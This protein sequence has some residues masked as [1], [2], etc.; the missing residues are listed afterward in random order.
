MS[1]INPGGF[2]GVEGIVGRDAEVARYW[3]VLARQSLVLSAERRIGKTYILKKMEAGSHEA[4][5]TFY[6]DLERVH[7]ITELIGQLYRTVEKHLPK[8]KRAR[9]KFI[10]GWNALSAQRI[11][12]L[13]LPTT[14]A[15]W[16]ALLELAVND[17][18][19]LADDDQ[20]VVFMW[21]EF[22][23][24][25]YNLIEREGAD[26][27]I[28]LL[29][30]LRSLRQTRS[31]Q[32]R[33]LFTGSIGLH[34]I[35]KR[36]RREGNANSPVNDTMQET[37]PPMNSADIRELGARLAKALRT[38]PVDEEAI[39]SRAIGHVGGFAFHL[40]HVFDRL[41]QLG[42]P[43]TPEDV[44][45]VANALSS[46][47]SDPADLGNGIERLHRYYASED[48]PVCLGILDVLATSEAP[49]DLT[50]I[51]NLVRHAKPEVTDEQVRH[52]SLL[53]KQDH[54]L[55]S[56]EGRH[57]FRWGL[58]KRWWKANRV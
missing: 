48:V 1:V 7:S 19:D 58:V 3:E 47:D 14:S 51:A 56:D 34:L 33:F 2:L 49:L 12:E 16:K 13:S 5:L 20:M 11:E 8:L 26:R 23:L 40:H 52:A 10:R 24:M 31:R 55:T 38:P 43:A 44:D 29:D 50:T 37:V 53:L 45:H 41:N 9:S 17:A 30:L 36:L 42:R 15:N 22:P 6:Q 39:I 32:L 21:D 28:E 18:L 46:G 4:F 35:L 54:Y 27:A 57:A 25:L